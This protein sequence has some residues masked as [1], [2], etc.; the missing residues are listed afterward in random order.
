MRFFSKAPD[1]G[2]GSGV[3]GYFLVEIKPLFSIVLLHFAK[4]TR[5]AFHEHA[6]NALTI[7][8]KGK[9]REHHL[10][11]ETKDFRVG[12]IKFTG[13]ACFHK[14]EALTSTW[15]LSFRGPWRDT[16]REFRNNRF[17]KL[18]HGRREV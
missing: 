10:S 5:E 12:Q 18:T 9:V 17:V 15:A 13:R 2:R 3:T 11:G 1:G 16:W 6:F 8:L 7:W 14:I 4:G